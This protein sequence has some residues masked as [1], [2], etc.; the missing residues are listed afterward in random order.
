MA[1]KTK[2]LEKNEVNGQLDARA[3]SSSTLKKKEG[4]VFASLKR[5][6]G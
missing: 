5:G 3:I 2:V 4:I 6:K 1:L